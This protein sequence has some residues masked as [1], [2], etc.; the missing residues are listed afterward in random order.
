MLLLL[1]SWSLHAAPAAASALVALVLLVPLL[2]QILKR[3][4]A[5]W[6]GDARAW[7]EASSDLNRA[8]VMAA[9]MPHQAYLSADAIVRACY[10]LGISKRHLLEWQTA[11]MSQRSAA[12][13]SGC[14]PSAILPHFRSGRR[15][16]GGANLRGVFWEPAWTPFL[17][18]WVAAPA[19]QYWIG[20]QRRGCEEAGAN[21]E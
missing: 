9:F 4:I 7:R 17:L 14:F 5:R 13:P 11:E 10:R 18:L 1:F 3:L 21:R 6:R 15:I 20:W 16:S 19:V 12:V 2:F 8:I